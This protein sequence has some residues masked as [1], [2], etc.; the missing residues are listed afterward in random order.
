MILVDYVA[1]RDL[2]IPREASSD[3]ALWA[4]L[5]AAATAVGAARVF[6]NRTGQGILD[7]HVP[8]MSR[9]VPAIDLIDFGYPYFH[10]PEDSLDKVSPRSLDLVGET[11]VE[12]LRRMSRET[13]PRLY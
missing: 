12:L 8:Y 3:P 1:D 6:P 4:R 9:G 7:D 13:C 2:S 5:R 11:L 10:T